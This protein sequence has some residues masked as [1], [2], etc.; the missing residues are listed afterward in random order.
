MS[1]R[2]WVELLAGVLAVVTT[3]AGGSVLLHELGVHRRHLQQAHQDHRRLHRLSAR[4]AG[5]VF[6]LEQSIT[7]GAASSEST[8]IPDTVTG[9]L[10]YLYA[11]REE[12]E[13]FVQR[14]RDHNSA[15]TWTQTY[16][17]RSSVTARRCGAA[18]TALAQAAIA[19][20][21]AARSYEEGTTAAIRRRAGTSTG[22]G[23]G[24]AEPI[25]LVRRRRANALTAARGEF[26][27]QMQ[28]VATH[29]RNAHPG[30]LHYRCDWPV[31]TSELARLT[32]D[33]YRGEVRPVSRAG[34]GDAPVLHLDAR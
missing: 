1:P 18:H 9:H 19:I 31:Y 7:A 8:A 15:I 14:A 33:P 23:P 32:D 20:G 34:F 29:T 22:P 10:T 21:L 13:L 2:E 26:E 16:L 28:L 12:S 17:Q 11:I 5:C 25:A 27:T 3:V 4:L 30:L 24:P 6:E